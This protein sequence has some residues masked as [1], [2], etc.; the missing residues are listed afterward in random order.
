MSNNLLTIKCFFFCFPKARFSPFFYY[1]S[2]E[3]P[4]GS[5]KEAEGPTPVPLEVPSADPTEEA[6]DHKPKLCRLEKGAN[7]YGFHL[8]AIRGRPGS[9][10]KEVW[11]LAPAAQRTPPVRA[12]SA[13]N[14]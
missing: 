9:F 13:S 1:Q 8:N 10:V 12:V 2:Q 7:G 6:E 5:V 3:L 4:N 11:Y 14:H